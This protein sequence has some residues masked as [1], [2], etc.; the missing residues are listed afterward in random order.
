M[1]EISLV[2]MLENVFHLCIS[3]A[4]YVV[5]IVLKQPHIITVLPVGDR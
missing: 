4:T 3:V 5:E 2:D 1:I